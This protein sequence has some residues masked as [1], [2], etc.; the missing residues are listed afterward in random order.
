MARWQCPATSPLQGL[1]MVP[2]DLCNMTLTQDTRPGTDPTCQFCSETTQGFCVVPVWERER[3][4]DCPS[5]FR[6]TT[7]SP[8]FTEGPVET[9]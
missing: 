6:E 1:A 2:E 3:G 4:P 8:G 7:W 9:V 5:G